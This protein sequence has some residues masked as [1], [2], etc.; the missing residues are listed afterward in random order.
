MYINAKMIP[1]ETIPG[2]RARRV[3][4]GVNSNMLYLIHCKKFCKCHN[5]LP[6]STIINKR[7]KINAYNN[8]R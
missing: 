3:V 1:V 2:M 6:P 8:I 5:L 7:N 4:E